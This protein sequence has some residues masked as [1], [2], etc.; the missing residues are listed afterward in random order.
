MATTSARAWRY[1]L[2]LVSSI[3]CNNTICLWLMDFLITMSNYMYCVADICMFVFPVL[4]A[5]HLGRQPK[6]AIY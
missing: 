1:D 5:P 2:F 3:N 4:E 6:Q